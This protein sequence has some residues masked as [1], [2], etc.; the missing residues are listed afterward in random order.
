M[1]Y[2][3]TN[4]IEE[5]LSISVCPFLRLYGVV[6]NGLRALARLVWK[7]SKASSPPSAKQELK[8]LSKTDVESQPQVDSEEEGSDKKNEIEQ[9]EPAI[10][11]ARLGEHTATL[12]SW[13][14]SYYFAP[15]ENR[16]DVNA[17]C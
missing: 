10:K 12:D 3:S 7:T 17:A 14:L 6:G 4:R 11:K 16:R 8:S 9:L 1:E 13:P 15:N 5:I 2:I